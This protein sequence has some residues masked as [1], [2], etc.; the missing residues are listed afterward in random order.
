MIFYNSMS[1]QQ[2][3]QFVILLPLYATCDMTTRHVGHL[4]RDI[5]M[6]K[7]ALNFITET[8]NEPGDACA[9]LCRKI[10]MTMMIIAGQAS[11]HFLQLYYC[12]EQVERV[13][14]KHEGVLF[15][16]LRLMVVVVVVCCQLYRSMCLLLRIGWSNNINSVSMN[17]DGGQGGQ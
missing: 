15:L 7:A 14:E 6:L 17:I 16:I 9:K 2:R 3:V 1:R 12:M 8:P 5:I 10:M 13:E 11:G 4:R